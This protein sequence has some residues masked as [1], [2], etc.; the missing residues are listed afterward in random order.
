[1]DALPQELQE[2]ILHLKTT[3]EYDS[4]VIQRYYTRRNKIMARWDA[5]DTYEQECFTEGI[6]FD[7]LIHVHLKLSNLYRWYPLFN[8][9]N[10]NVSNLKHMCKINKLKNYSNKRK[11]ELINLLISME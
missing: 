5:Y 11:A 1:M 10:Q 6:N 2:Y 8:I 3:V 9:R 4:D 7:I